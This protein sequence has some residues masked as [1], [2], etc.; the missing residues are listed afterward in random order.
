[1]DTLVSA[2]NVSING[3][4]DADLI[5]TTGDGITVNANSG[6]DYVIARGRGSYIYGGNG[7]DS[8]ILLPSVAS[9]AT[10]SGG[11]GGSAGRTVTVAAETEVYG[12]SGNDDIM[13]VHDSAIV[14]G[15]AGS[16]MKV[17]GNFLLL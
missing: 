3:S 16:F 1:M 17:Q 7:N 8:L 10:T 4:A 12:D 2:S 13:I 11:S 5:R 15:G 9:S 14:Y 6:D